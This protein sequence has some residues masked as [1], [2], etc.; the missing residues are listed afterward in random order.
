MLLLPGTPS[1]TRRV[2]HTHTVRMPL[3]RTSP[4]QVPTCCCLRTIHIEQL[5]Q[6]EGGGELAASPFGKVEQQCNFDTTCCLSTKCRA[7]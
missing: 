5:E 7:K 1:C 2:Y 4:A 6:A 3:P